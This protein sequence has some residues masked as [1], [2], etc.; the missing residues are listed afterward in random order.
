MFNTA[1]VFGIGPPPAEKIPWTPL[2]PPRGTRNA[3]ALYAQYA[4][5]GHILKLEVAS[6]GFRF[7]AWNPVEEHPIRFQ[8]VSVLLKLNKEQLAILQET[9]NLYRI[10]SEENQTITEAI[11]ELHG[12]TRRERDRAMREIE[13]I[14][15][16]R[17][18]VTCGPAGKLR[19][20]WQRVGA[21]QPFFRCCS[22]YARRMS[23]S[24]IA[25]SM[26]TSH[27]MIQT[28]FEDAP[29]SFDVNDILN[30]MDAACVFRLAVVIEAVKLEVYEGLYRDESFL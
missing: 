21:M 23:K 4:D 2:R 24:T 9:V 20:P 19:A 18:R 10:Y 30:D 1:P 5:K 22:M 3:R 6:N 27:V 26:D 25:F 12:V 28:V 29:M 17:T 8:M 13:R 11:A 7:L 16:R 15:G 14:F